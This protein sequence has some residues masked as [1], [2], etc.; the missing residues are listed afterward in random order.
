M[1]EVKVLMALVEDNDAVSKEGAR[2]G[3]W[4]KI[5]MRKDTSSESQRNII[6]PLVGVTNSLATDYESQRN[7]TDQQT[8]DPSSSGQKYLGFVKYSVDDT[9]VSIPAIDYDSAYESLVC[10]TLLPPLKKLDGAEPVSGPKT[11]KS[12]LKSKSTFKVEALKYDIRKPI[13][14]LDSGC[15]R[16][17]TG[18]KSYPHKYVEQPGP[19]VVFGDD[20]TCTT[21][22]SENLNWLWH[23]RFAHLNFKTF[24]RLAK[25]N[26]VIGL[27]SLVQSKDKACSLCVKG[28]HHKASFKTKQTFSIKKYLH[29]LHMDLFGP[30]TPRSI[31]HE[32][33][34][35]VIVDEYSMYTWVYFLKRKSQA[36]ETIMSF[37]KRVENQNEIKVKQLRTNNGTDF[38]NSILIN[39]CDEKLISQKTNSPYTP[40]QNGVAKRKNRTLIDVSRTMLSG[41][42]FSKQ[43]WTEAIA[44][45]CYTQNRSTIVKIHLKTAYE[46]FR[47]KIPNI[48][49]L[50]VF[51]CPV[52]I[53]NHK[54]HLEKFDEKADDSYFLEY[55]LVSKAFRVFNIRRQQTKE[56]YHIT[57]NESLD[58]IKFIKPS[59]DNINIAKSK[60]YPPDEYSLLKGCDALVDF[61]AEA[62]SRIFAPND[63]I[64]EQQGMD[65]GTQDYSLDYIFTGTNPSVLVDKTKSARDG[66]KTAEAIATAC[67]TQNRSLVIPRHE[68]TPYHIIKSRNP[69]AKSF[70]IFGSLYYIVKDGE[71]LDKMKEKGDACIFV[72]YSTQSRAYRVFNKRTRIIVETVPVNFDELPHM[73]L[74]HVNSDLVPQ[75]SMTKLEHESLSPCPQSQENAPRAAETVRTS[76]ELDLLFSLMFDELINETTLVVSKTFAVHAVDDPNKRQQHTTT[77]SSTTTVSVKTPP[78]NIQTTPKT[79][80][81]AP[82]VTATENNN[83]AKM[84]TENAQVEDDEFINIFCTPI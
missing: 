53:H 38:K 24:N 77:Q 21:E 15:S 25:Q 50:Y 49:F 43:Y 3:D 80:C 57:F 12:I 64:P 35:L 76:N 42:I 84:I 2:N 75:C 73:A 72:G 65:E 31:N 46:I 10:S 19:K 41:S 48:D 34:I 79:T 74:D 4:I 59:I 16:H 8:E 82:T 69:S 67:F 39:F 51:G 36:H 40:E 14:Y 83:Q 7:T 17:M 62:D 22:A 66:L 70:Y 9:K 47:K 27:P 6:N 68:K 61:I 13:C 5:S 29:L 45:A 54:D 71:N 30:V 37:I 44:T 20:S 56:T 33:Y 18:V 63:F 60:R 26:L 11:I 1:A 81:Q 23:K 28:K 55:S 58:A 52:F 78:L 32:K